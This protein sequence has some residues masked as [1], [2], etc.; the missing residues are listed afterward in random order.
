MHK[1]RHARPVGTTRRATAIS[2][3]RA[4]TGTGSG[5]SKFKSVAYRMINEE[6]YC[7]DILTQ[8]SAITRALDSVALDLLDDHRC[9]C[10]LDAATTGQLVSDLMIAGASDAITRLVRS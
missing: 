7:V 10:V 3:T 1:L 4:R 8:I 2:P 6:R 5:A 9:H